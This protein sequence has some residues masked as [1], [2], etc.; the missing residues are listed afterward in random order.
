MVYILLQKPQKQIKE[1]QNQSKSYFSSLTNNL[2]WGLMIYIR[3]NLGGRLEEMAVSKAKG[4][5][6]RVLRR[7]EETQ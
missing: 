7:K 3:V 1:S 5:F 4:T 6:A 2:V